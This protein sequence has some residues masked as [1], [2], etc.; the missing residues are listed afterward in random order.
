[1][2]GTT[3]STFFDYLVT[4]KTVTPPEFAPWYTEKFAYMPNCYQINS[5]PPTFSSTDNSKYKVGLPEHGFV[6][7]S[8]CTSY[9]IDWNIFTSW[10]N[11]L[12]RVPGSFLWLLKDSDEFASRILSEASRCGINEKR[13]I[14]AQ[15]IGHAEHLARLP[16][17]DLALDTAIA[18]G[19]ATTS[20]ALWAGLPVVTLLGRHFIS[21][22]TASI[23]NSMGLKNLIAYNLKEYEDIAVWLAYNPEELNKIRR[24]VN[25]TNLSKTLYNTKRSVRYLEALYE[26]MWQKHRSGESPALIDIAE[27][28]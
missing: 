12:D 18:S 8:F 27:N 17:A 14:F 19:A 10:A 25:R 1:M 20:D 15:R 3:G 5:K 7:C 4:D 23:L 11:I 16:Y 2:P 24:Q 21:R 22:M 6:F 13:I 26:K 28:H 9:K